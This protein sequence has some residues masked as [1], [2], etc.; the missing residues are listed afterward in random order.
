MLLSNLM[1]IKKFDSKLNGLTW[2]IFIWATIEVQVGVYIWSL[3]LDRN[4][5]KYNTI[6]IILMTEEINLRKP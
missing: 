5:T 2:I 4:G 1:S 6:V 3:A